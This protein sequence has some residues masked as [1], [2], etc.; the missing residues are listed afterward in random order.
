MLWKEQRCLDLKIGEGGTTECIV[1]LH[2][3]GSGVYS[4]PHPGLSLETE[5]G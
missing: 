5:R 2:G 1:G 4:F 3:I